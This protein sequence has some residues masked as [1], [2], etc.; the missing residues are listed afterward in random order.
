MN[1]EINNNQHYITESF[2][3]KR[4]G[5]NGFVHRYD[6]RYDSWKANASPQFV[7]S[8]PGYT[9]FLEE[10]Q[11]V[12]NSLEISF[13]N[14]ENQLQFIFPVLD[15]A[16]ERAEIMVSEQ[17][18]KDLCFYCA[19][20]WYLSP[21]AKAKASANFVME[22]DFNLKHGNWDYLRKRGM[23]ESAIQRMKAQ[24]DAGYQFVLRGDNYLQFVFRDQF[25]RNCRSQAGHFRYHT[26]WT[27][28]NSPIELPISDIALVDMPEG[29]T[30]TL[31]ILPI[32]PN[33]VLIGRLQHGT[34]PPYFSTDAK[35]YGDILTAEAAQDVLDI[36]CSSAVKAIACKN[37]MDIKAIRQRAQKRKVAFTKIA[38][39]DDVLEAGSKAFDRSKDLFLIPVSS[40]EYVK[41]L[42]SF[43]RPA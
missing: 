25:V 35:I 42:H 13:S 32:S 37:R 7:F 31:Y 17:I 22:L 23:P 43:I 21:F 20:L 33:R 1:N 19:Y 3:K 26:K 6:V 10:G 11:P 38:N 16:A 39:L 2:I 5:Q 24:F 29:K 36:I 27:V 15:D 28:Y 9:Q 34:P 12:D 40:D 41:Y 14:L 18:F 4:F 30:A 8:A